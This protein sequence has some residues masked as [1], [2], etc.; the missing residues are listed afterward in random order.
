[1]KFLIKQYHENVFGKAQ[2]SNLKVTFR[3][4]LFYTY[5]KMSHVRKIQQETNRSRDEQ[6]HFNTK[7]TLSLLDSIRAE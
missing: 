5:T 7:A 3:N 4:T 2:M 1:M 6:T